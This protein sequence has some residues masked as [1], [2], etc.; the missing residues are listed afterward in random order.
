LYVAEAAAGLDWKQR[1]CAE[2][3]SPTK[4]LFCQLSALR[5]CCQSEP[6]A[7]RGKV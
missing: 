7:I 4:P 3:T 1:I 6:L 2:L 5:T